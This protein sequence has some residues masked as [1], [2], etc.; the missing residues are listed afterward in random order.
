[1]AAM[2]L[3]AWL[4]TGGVLEVNN[5]PLNDS[6]TPVASVAKAYTRHGYGIHYNT[7]QYG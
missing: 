7:R 5:R 6:L 3:Q 1:M 2:A 4:R